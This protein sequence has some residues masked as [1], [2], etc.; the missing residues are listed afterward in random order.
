MHTMDTT[1]E[2][3]KLIKKLLNREGMLEKL[4]CTHS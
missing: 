4:K 1:S 2:L 3:S